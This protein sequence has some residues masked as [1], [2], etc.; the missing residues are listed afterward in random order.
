MTELD[1]DSARYLL[2][3][4]VAAIFLAEG[5]IMLGLPSL[6]IHNPFFEA[7]FNATVLISILFP[8]LYFGVF[9]EIKAK[10]KQIMEMERQVRS[11]NIEL[12]GRVLER[13]HQLQRTNDQLESVLARLNTTHET[14]ALVRGMHRLLHS[15][16]DEN[17]AYKIIE[18]NLAK[19]L[20][21]GTGALYITKASRNQ[22]MRVAQWP[23]KA[24]W[25]TSFSPDACW[26][27]R[28]GQAYSSVDEGAIRCHHS[29]HKTRN[30]PLQIC[31]PLVARGETLG[32]LSVIPKPQLKNDE[33]EEFKEFVSAIA[34]GIALSVANV[35]MFRK[36]EAQAF[37]DQQTGLFN[38]HFLLRQ[39]ELE[40]HKVNRSKAPLSLIMLDVDH[41]KKFNDLHGH[42]AG[43]AVLAHFGQILRKTFRAGDVCCRYG[44]EEFVVLLPNASTKMAFKR[45][46]EFLKKLHG[47]TIQH[48]GE[49][50]GP[51]TA[52][53]G[54][55]TYKIH[56]NSMDELLKAADA[57]LYSSKEAGRDQVTEAQPTSGKSN[58][59][60]TVV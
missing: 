36:L 43:D 52:S 40:I 44:G 49:V 3:F 13:T 50:L 26:S 42:D 5:L 14:M 23:E 37:E 54:V 58:A 2:T 60:L 27:L 6:A 56:G 59:K 46:N 9:K 51:I 39:I 25:A 32:V 18:T 47:F 53:A 45:A 1:R 17:E 24:G 57:A 8:L 15:A 11:A 19:I 20:P 35:Q 34:G 7:I 21:D 28:L 30:E 12:E 33:I 38:R 10:S 29:K 48:N 16:Q 31:I 41:F 22:L 55:A 4:L